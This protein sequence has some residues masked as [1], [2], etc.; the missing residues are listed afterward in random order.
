MKNAILPLII[1]MI[2]SSCD[3]SKAQKTATFEPIIKDLDRPTWLTS[4]I[5][6]ERYLWILEKDGVIL[7]YDK[8]DK[9]LL[10]KPFLDISQNIK[11]KMNEQGLLGLAFAP[12]Y[13]KTGKF[14]IN[15]TNIEGDTEILRFENDL[16]TPLSCES[17]SKELLLTIK[18]DFKNHNGGWIDFG[19]DN[20]LYI[21]MG[22]G[23]SGFDPKNRAQ[24][25]NSH[26][27]KLLRIDVSSANGY[28]IPKDNPFI[29]NSKAKKEIYSYGLR[30]PWRCSFDSK[31]NL[32]I[33]DVGQ[34]T[35]EE[36]NALHYKDARG[37]NF[38]WKIREGLIPT[39]PKLFNK[40]KHP[41]KKT[42]PLNNHI[43]PVYTYQ[44][45]V[46]QN[47][48]LSITGGYVY[49]GKIKK[50][51]GQYFFADFVNP[52][53]WSI[54]YDGKKASNFKDLTNELQPKKGSKIAQIA[55]FGTDSTGEFYLI[56]HQGIIYQLTE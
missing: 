22:D 20:M 17:S 27:G 23:G 32:F 10:P 4:P 43:E 5:G 54:S 7:I 52:R 49:E 41:S 29:K 36:V 21:A 16:N 53:I 28:T 39:P 40:K 15:L 3:S 38:G 26:L 48:G 25:L 35:E 31:G 24:D 56:S 6:E 8:Q 51:Q 18:Q 12:D 9:K 45:G 42:T 19:P 14:Y 11:I 33:A 2:L 13:M 55:S 34:R 46:K 50:Y 47:Q 1:T 44:H 30:N 37:A